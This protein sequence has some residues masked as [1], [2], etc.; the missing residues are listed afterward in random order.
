MLRDIDAAKGTRMSKSLASNLE[1]KPDI[2]PIVE[3][4][5]TLKRAGH[6]LH[7]LCPLHSEKTPSF[8]VNPDKQVFYCHGC[9]QGGDVIA[10][11]RK[12]ERVSYPEAIAR[13]GIHNNYIRKPVNTRS[14]RAAA[15]LANWLNE[16]HLKVGALL[17]ELSQQIS[18]AEQIPDADLIES[19]NREWEILSDLH[20]DL[21]RPERAEE[22]LEAKDSIEAI[23]ALAPV[24]PLPEFPKWTREY[25]E[26]L[27]AHLPQ[28]ESAC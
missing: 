25:A 8:T 5:T 18:I 1:G 4:Y 24:E 3:Q 20:A 2:V 14:R 22:L 11:I 19:L 7:G 10:L 16:Q 23:T 21:Q 13:L 9:H 28:M 12:L 26:Y 6:Q 17:R 27:V 15:K